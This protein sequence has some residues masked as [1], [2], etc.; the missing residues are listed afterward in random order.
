MSLWKNISK[1]WGKVCSHTR[2]K[3]GDA[4]KLDFGMT[5]GVGMTLKDAFPILFDIACA[6]DAPIEAHMELSRGDI[7]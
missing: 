7:Q 6:K 2:F 5:C 1:G 3:V 4:P